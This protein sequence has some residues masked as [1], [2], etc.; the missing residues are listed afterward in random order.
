MN[1]IMSHLYT[2]R[3]NS[4]QLQVFKQLKKFRSFFVLAGGIAIMLQLNHRLSQDFDCF[5]QRPLS[6]Y[7]SAKLTEVFGKEIKVIF[8]SEDMVSFQTKTNVNISFVYYPYKPLHPAIKTETIDLSHLDDLAANKAFT[9]GRR[10]TWR[11]YVDLFWFLNSKTYNMNQLIKLTEKKFKGEFNAKLFLGQLTYYKDVK[12]VPTVFTKQSF[13]PEQ[14]Q[15]FLQQT[16][17]D[18]LKK[19]GLMF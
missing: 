7:F 6:T 3:L 14:I 19:E 11:D 16:V 17:R 12:I 9:V 13:T 10:N 2:D 1:L 5:S 8:K 18:Y 4:E 15:S